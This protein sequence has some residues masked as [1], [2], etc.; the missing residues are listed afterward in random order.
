ADIRALAVARGRVVV[1]PEHVEQAVEIDLVRIELDL[2][3]FRMAGRT[4][5]HLLIGR[6]VDITAGIAHYYVGHAGHAAKQ[7]VRPSEAAHRKCCRG[8][9]FLHFEMQGKYVALYDYCPAWR[10]RCR[11]GP[12][13]SKRW[14]YGRNCKQTGCRYF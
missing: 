7:T 3:G 2:H 4:A 8:H 6:I 12:T 1:V 14:R 10:M 13:A 9:L 11:V 5:A